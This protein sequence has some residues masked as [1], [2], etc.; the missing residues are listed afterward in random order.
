MEHPHLHREVPCLRDLCINH[1]SNR[2]PGHENPINS[3]GVL[4]H[5]LCDKILSLLMKNKTLTPKSIQAFLSWYAHNNCQSIQALISWCAH[6]NCQS[7]QDLISWYAHNNCQSIQALI[8]WCAHNNFPCFT[9]DF[10][11]GIKCVRW[12]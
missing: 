7:I 5:D 3:L 10:Y 6:N 1:I 11:L 12:F 9:R 4:P 8:S 2:L